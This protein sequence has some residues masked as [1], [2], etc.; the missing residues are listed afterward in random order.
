MMLDGYFV[1]EQPSASTIADASELG[2]PP[3][4]IPLLMPERPVAVPPNEWLQCLEYCYRYM[5][6]PIAGINGFE[7]GQLAAETFFHAPKPLA[8]LFGLGGWLGFTSGFSLANIPKVDATTRIVALCSGI[9]SL[10]GA[11]PSAALTQQSMS[12]LRSDSFSLIQGYAFQWLDFFA[13]GANGLSN[14]VLGI[15]EGH[16]WGV[17]LKRFYNELF[18]T[19]TTNSEKAVM[20]FC[21]LLIAYCAA[22]S[23]VG[24]TPPVIGLFTKCGAPKIFANICGVGANFAEWAFQTNTM[25]A[26][27]AE[28]RYCGY[29]TNPFPTD[30]R[31]TKCLSGLSV[32]V[33]LTSGLAMSAYTYTSIANPVLAIILASTAWMGGFWSITKKTHECIPKTGKCLSTCICKCFTDPCCAVK[34]IYKCCIY[35]CCYS[36]DAVDEFETCC[37]F[38]KTSSATPVITTQPTMTT[39]LL[40]SPVTTYGTSAPPMAR[41]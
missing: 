30:W 34:S 18:D 25:Y 11:L 35:P 41:S 21:G 17:R 14:F 29:F 27:K 4:L 3:D 5:I 6:S 15:E 12:Q 40:P 33:G 16:A 13:A 20:I 8:W 36:Q 2:L 39:P 19:T 22:T 24:Y 26:F 1:T 37:S 9:N 10:I 28:E 31:K 38:L 7:G 23:L 32:L